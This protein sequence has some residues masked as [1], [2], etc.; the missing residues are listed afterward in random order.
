MFRPVALT[1]SLALAVA[2]A[3][4]S[5]PELRRYDRVEIAPT[6]TSI[7]VGT[8]SMTMPA[9]TRTAGAYESSY[10]A[11]VFPW[12]FQSETGRLRVAV[13]DEMERGERVEIS[14]LAVATNGDERRLEGHATPDGPGAPTGKIKLR[15]FVSKRIELVFNT[16]Y[17]FP[18]SPS[19]PLSP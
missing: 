12:F 2:I 19:L 16:T 9:F 11:K 7:Y 17:R 3:R 14:G 6:K 8:V 18:D 1:L 10:A 15:V 5:E 4:A 13:T